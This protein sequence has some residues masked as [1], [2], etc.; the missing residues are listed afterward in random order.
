MSYILDALRKSEQERRRT[1]SLA[2]TAGLTEAIALPQRRIAPGAIVAGGVVLFAVIGA[3]L[4]MLRQPERIASTPIGIERPAP[5]ATTA[6]E[7]RPTPPAAESMSAPGLASS[8]IKPA[9]PLDTGHTRSDARDL[10]AEALTEPPKPK[11]PVAH[12]SVEAAS[13]SADTKL[14]MA[15]PANEPIKFLN[16]MPPQ[17]RQ[18]LPELS[19]N[20]HIYAPREADRILYINNRQYHSGDHVRDGVIVEAIVEDGAVLSFQGQRFKLPRPR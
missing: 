8:E 14:A 10:A 18:A 3:G 1:D 17:F 19:V 2:P 15:A 7:N 6:E 9:L 20:I 4:Y 16:A 5:V 12:P 11:T 13:V